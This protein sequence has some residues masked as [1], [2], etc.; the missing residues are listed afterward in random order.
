MFCF[1]F[2]DIIITFST[3]EEL[4]SN[5]NIIRWVAAKELLFILSHPLDFINLYLS[6]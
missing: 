1:F 2:L 4:Y 5:I 3:S 6:I